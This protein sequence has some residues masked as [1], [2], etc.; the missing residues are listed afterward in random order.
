MGVVCVAGVLGALGG[1]AH[2]GQVGMGGGDL[3]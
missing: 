1:Y 3:L 2:V